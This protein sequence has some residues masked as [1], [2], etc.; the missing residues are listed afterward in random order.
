MNRVAV[1]RIVVGVLVTCFAIG[2][3]T[4]TLH[5]LNVGWVVFSAAP[6]WMNVYWTVLTGLDPLAAMLLLQR[7]AR[8]LTLGVAIMLSDV[9]TNSYALYG[10]GLPFGFL[11]L[12]FQTLFCGFL[13]GATGFLLRPAPPHGPPDSVN[14][15]SLTISSPAART[16]CEPRAFA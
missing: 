9:G 1:E 12:Q 14:S 3:T 7:R 4:H 6:T 2:T 11:S 8:G 15:P 10:L 16:L 5:F 13:L